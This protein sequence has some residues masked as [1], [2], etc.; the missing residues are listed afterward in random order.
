MQSESKNTIT[1]LKRK[2]VYRNPN[3]LTLKTQSGQNDYKL[4]FIFWSNGKKKLKVDV[5]PTSSV[6]QKC[7]NPANIYKNSQ[8]VI[9]YDCVGRLEPCL[10]K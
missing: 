6:N 8:W 5:H 4:M 7:L 1:Y 2:M 3:P 9:V 10:S